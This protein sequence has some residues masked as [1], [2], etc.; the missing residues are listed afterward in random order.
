MM[1]VVVAAVS[2]FG[3]AQAMVALA[4]SPL[5]AAKAGAVLGLTAVPMAPGPESAGIPKAADGHYWA[6][7]E[8][9]GRPVRF[10]VDTGATAVSLTPRDALAL[11]IRPEDL[12]YGAS[13]ITAGGRARA[14]TVRLATVSVAGAR[15]DDVDALVI[16][17]GLD[18]SLLGMSYL[19]RLSRFEASRDTLVLQP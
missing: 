16:E 4:P 19:G 1:L 10:L 5:R 3:G 11:G 18:A 14:A 17:S 12:R 9:N 2:A 13:V 15:L 6:D 8:V 7:A